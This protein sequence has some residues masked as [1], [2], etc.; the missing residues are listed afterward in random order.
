VAASYDFLTFV[1][2]RGKPVIKHELLATV[3]FNGEFGVWQRI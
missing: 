3:T 2:N 1:H